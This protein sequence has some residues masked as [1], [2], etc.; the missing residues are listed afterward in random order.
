LVYPTPKGDV[1]WDSDV[2]NT[3]PITLLEVLEKTLLGITTDRATAVCAKHDVMKGTNPSVLP[4]TSTD[5]TLFPIMSQM[6]HAREHNQE[7]WLVLLDIK[8]A[9]D[10]VD[11]EMLS[12][13]LRRVG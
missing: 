8:R 4:G 6:E 1:T 12:L 13:S 10:S 2:T 7:L 5:D 11:Y 9:F 3:R